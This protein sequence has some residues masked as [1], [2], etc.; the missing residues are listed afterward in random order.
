VKEE[1][2]RTIAGIGRYFAG[3]IEFFGKGVNGKHEW[4]I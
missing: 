3:R 4:K 2:L 1:V